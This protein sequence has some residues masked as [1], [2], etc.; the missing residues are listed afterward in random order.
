[1]GEAPRMQLTGEEAK[2]A[3]TRTQSARVRGAGTP[4]YQEHSHHRSYTYR[5]VSLI[6]RSSYARRV[7]DALARGM[8]TAGMS[9]AGM[10]TAGMSTAGMSTA[11][12]STAGTCCGVSTVLQ[13][14]LSSHQ[15]GR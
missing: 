9:T 6:L 2:S 11:G 13:Q 14:A 1:M 3:S 7:M 15:R 8:S 10:S 5:A 12:M 4:G